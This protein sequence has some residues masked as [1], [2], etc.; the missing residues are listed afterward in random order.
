MQW[1]RIVL[2][3]VL[4][5]MAAMGLPVHGQKINYTNET[6]I[7]TLWSRANFFSP[8]ALTAQTFHGVQFD[9][10]LSMGVTAGIDEYF[11][12]RVVPIA[13]GSRAVLPCE[14]VSPY[15]GVEVGYG[16]TWFEKQTHTEW[17]DGGMMF[18]PAIGLRW[19]ANGRD[20]YLIS[21]GY[22]RQVVTQNTANAIQGPGAYNSSRYTL[23]RMAVRFGMIF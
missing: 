1:K 21:I 22:K 2:P 13:V 14:R 12:L 19:K 23:N 17:H 6:E 15:L 16:F 4:V 5:A 8:I 7:G 10:I 11:G 3:V 20:R 9:R 18:N